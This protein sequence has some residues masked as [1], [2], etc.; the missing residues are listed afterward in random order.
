MMIK[1]AVLSEEN[2]KLLGD[3]YNERSTRV[4]EGAY[5]L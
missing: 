3:D 4:Q 2:C 1:L 5:M